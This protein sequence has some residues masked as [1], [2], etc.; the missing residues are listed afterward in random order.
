MTVSTGAAAAQGGGLVFPWPA[1]PAAGETLEVAPGIHWLRLPLPFAL[2]HINVWL[3]EDGDGWTVVDTGVARDE[4]RAQWRIALAAHGERPVRRVVVTHYHPDHVGLAGWFAETQG[5]RLWMTRTEWLAARMY[6]LDTSEEFAGTFADFYRSAGGAAD[7]V[8]GVRQGSYDFPSLVTPVPRSYRRLVDGETF[9]MGGRRWRVVVGEGHSPE[10]ACLWCEEAGVLI[11]GDQVL[12]RISPIV[13]VMAPEPD[14]DPL[15]AFL[16]S[17]AK[18]KREIP[19]DALVLPSHNT[20][21]T[22]LHFRLDELAHHHDE[23]LDRLLEAV[24]GA[25][26]AMELAKA[27]FDR[28]LDHHQTGFALAE[29][30]SH[31]RVLETRGLIARSERAD[32]VW[33]YNRV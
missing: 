6:A 8:H 5:A 32:G 29:T 13:G 4:A 27:L 10:H 18:L 17:L 7:F 16:V 23:R 14:A 19:A 1:P 11:A 25:K 26:T 3:V 20:P 9:E 2:N 12:P 28:E 15:S 24:S 33:I 22:G 30:L 21:F 31:L